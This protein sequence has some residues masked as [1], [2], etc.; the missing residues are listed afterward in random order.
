MTQGADGLRAHRRLLIVLFA[1]VLIGALDISIV[2]PALPAIGAGFDVDTRALAWVFNTYVLVY[3]I[4]APLMGRLSDRYGR[5]PV[6][7]S[8][9]ALFGAG[10]VL[11]AIS[12]SFELLLTGRV[13]QAVGA[14]GLFPIASAVIGDVMPAHQ[15]GRALGLI[16]AV[17]GVAFLLG[18]LLGGLLLRWGWQW[19]F[20]V[21]VPIVAVLLWQCRAVLPHMP[22][23]AARPRFDWAGT[24]ALTV[25]LGSFAWAVTQLD[26][27]DLLRS[28]LAPDVLLFLV[29]AIVAMPLF[30]AAVKKAADPVLPPELLRRPQ[31]RLV[32]ALATAAGLVEAGMVFLPA[33]AI[34]AIG[35]EPATASLMMLPLVLALL[36]GAPSAGHLLDRIG[37]RPVIQ[38][39]LALT[40]AGLVV[41][42]VPALT[43]TLPVFYLAGVLVGLGLSG[44]LGAPLRAV[45]LREAGESH[46]GAGQGLLTLCLST[47]RLV[48]AALIGGTAAA[49]ADE[50][51]GYRQALLLLAVVIAAALLASA[52]LRRDGQGLS[53]A[54]ARG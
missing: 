23:G 26:G 45:M 18:P 34:L 17:F 38:V 39:G 5:Y 40:G 21:N 52:W 20:L 14:A 19:L 48:G 42:A 25:M 10:S 41:F 37:A 51:G 13:V 27:D 24:L 8:S 30:W 46:R 16:G 22:G 28:A 50:L 11:I 47:G 49:A 36:L 29:V 1:G 2:G 31:L 7:A 44:L 12:P 32:G 53:A 15:R 33:I 3:L 54:G 35:V 9:L 43:L 6:Y 4:A